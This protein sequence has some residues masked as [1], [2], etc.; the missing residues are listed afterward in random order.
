MDAKEQRNSLS[1]HS[2]NFF[3]D[4]SIEKKVQKRARNQ[5]LQLDQVI[6]EEEEE[7]PQAALQ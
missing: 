6:E 7:E 5:D 1:S 4:F 2:M 3:S